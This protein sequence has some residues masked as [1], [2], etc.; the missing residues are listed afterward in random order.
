MY[1][2]KFLML[3]DDLVWVKKEQ[4][5]SS[6]EWKLGIKW[7]SPYKV[8][9]VKHGG[10]SYDLENTFSGD[11]IHRAVDKLKRFVG[12]EGYIVDMSEI[13]LLSVN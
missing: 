2:K 13:V 12:D 11:T 9:E 3:L 4:I 8:K 7:I 6:I 10:V 1:Y 5:S